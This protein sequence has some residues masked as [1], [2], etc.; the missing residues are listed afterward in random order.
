M[1]EIHY[2]ESISL[3]VS[4]IYWQ[5]NQKIITLSLLMSLNSPIINILDFGVMV[6]DSVLGPKILG[7]VRDRIIFSCCPNIIRG[8]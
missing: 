8:F 1:L 4:F 5:D 6:L 7:R 3:K 2:L